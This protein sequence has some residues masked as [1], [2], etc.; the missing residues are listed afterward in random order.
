MK[1]SE[2]AI[3]FL[4][5]GVLAAYTYQGI[6]APRWTWQ[7]IA[8]AQEIAEQGST[9]RGPVAVFEMVKCAERLEAEVM[10]RMERRKWKGRV[11]A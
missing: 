11:Q 2:T 6:K 9:T 1:P 8:V 4:W 7:H 10:R 3:A 5:M